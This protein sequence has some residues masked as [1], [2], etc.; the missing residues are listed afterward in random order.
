MW[1]F[2]GSG[3]SV[4]FQERSEGL[5]PTPSLEIRGRLSSHDLGPGGLTHP[6]FEAVEATKKLEFSIVESGTPIPYPAEK[7][8]EGLVTERPGQAFAAIHYFEADAVTKFKKSFLG[9][10]VVLPQQ[11][12]ERVLDLYKLI[13][14]R[15]DMSHEIRAKFVGLVPEPDGSGLLS[16]REFTSEDFVI[17]KPYVCDEVNI[18]FYAS[19]ID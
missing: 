4:W 2:R 15:D 10:T 16:V 3:R 13:F 18:S 5:L 19:K 1:A 9:V 8:L 14:G 6:S 7:V 17:R 11:S 12:F